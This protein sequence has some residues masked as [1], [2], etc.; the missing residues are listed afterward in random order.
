MTCWLSGCSTEILIN[1]KQKQFRLLELCSQGKVKMKQGTL[2]MWF[3][4]KPW[5]DYLVDKNVT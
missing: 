1:I 3:V 4:Q 2:L 5:Y